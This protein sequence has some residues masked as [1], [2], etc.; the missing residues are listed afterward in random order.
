[1]PH[2]QRGPE[3]LPGT[4][5]YDWL[6]SVVAAVERRTGR[7]SSWNRQL[8]E[9]LGQVSGSGQIGGH[10]TISRKNVL[11]PVLRAYDANRPT[12][13]ETTGGARIGVLVVVHETDHH[14]HE[15][16]DE[17]APDAVRYS[18]A[19][20]QALTEGLAD[21]NRD[22]IVDL[23]IQ[24]IGMDKAVPRI[25][26]MTATLGYAGYQTAVE[27]VLDGLHTVSGRP[28][29]EVL[30]AVDGTPFAQRYNAMADVLIDS[31]LN[32][33]MPPQH[34][35]QIRL[36]L[37]R[38]LQE[39]LGAITEHYTAMQETPRELAERGREAGSRAI[40]RVEAELRT[41][42]EHYHEAGEQP[43]RL[44]MTARE[45]AQ[46]QEIET[47]YGRPPLELEPDRLRQFLN[48]TA[49]PSAVRVAAD[50]A[51]M[52]AGAEL[53]AAGRR[54]SAEAATGGN[55]AGVAGGPPAGS[56][57][58]GGTSAGS[59][60]A[61]GASAG[62]GSGAGGAAAG[63]GAAGRAAAE[64]G[65]GSGAMAAAR[66]A[67]A[68]AAAARASSLAGDGAAAGGSATGGASAGG[69]AAGEG[70]AAPAVGGASTGGAA[71]GGRAGP[72]ASGTRAGG[73]AAGGGRAGQA[74]GG[75]SGGGAAP[76]VGGANAGGAAAGESATGGGGAVSGAAVGAG[77]D[78]VDAATGAVR[79]AAA[80]DG[81]RGAAGA[82]EGWR[83]D[84]GV[85]VVDGG[86]AALGSPYDLGG[87]EVRIGADGRAGTGRAPGA[88]E[89]A[90]RGRGGPAPAV[91][92]DGDRRRESRRVQEHR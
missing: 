74:A 62:A 38:P 90:Y 88:G 1:M 85:G 16:G 13:L 45:R 33:V 8:Y 48:S 36:R 18:S 77:S 6:A 76:V 12:D 9:E 69:A 64:M 70:G 28:R 92:R 20:G 84:S 42:E 58:A 79:A 27:G 22:R 44:P 67:A 19:A 80:G 75:A 71:G 32:G 31:R 61:G 86:S 47:Y 34:R 54:P 72:A 40:E 49:R 73:A 59:A 53:S 25:H 68:G 39:E 23:V 78:Q 83:G 35:S 60:G 43:S 56:A 26:D 81:R 2:Q 37:T 57:A 17:N 66:A 5:E 89:A 87:P 41:V 21:S 14:Q 50:S 4:R 15:P 29:E 65:T 52:S 91:C 3:I 7:P 10:M 24:D 63:G 51:A 30:A 46:V 82:R 11:E 55:T